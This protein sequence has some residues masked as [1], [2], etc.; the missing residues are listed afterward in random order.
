MA[1]DTLTEL[2][3]RIDFA[4]ITSMHIIYPPLTIGLAALLFFSEWRWLRTGEDSW[5][6][7]TRFYEKL[8]IINFGAGVAT[9]VTMEMAFGILYGPFSTAVGPV[10]GHLLGTETITAFMYEAG[11][12]GLMVFGWHKINPYVHL[13]A[14]FNVAFAS[15]LSAFWIL[16]ANSWMQTP[17]GVAMSD[18][19]FY[20]TDWLKVIFNEDSL[21]AT[22]HMLLACL[23]MGLYFVAGVAAWQ[24]LNKRHTLLFQR[25]LKYAVLAMVIVAGYQIWHGDELGLT[26][27]H[28][29]PAALAAM[30]GHF[31]TYLPNGDPNT[32]WNL[33]MWPNQD[34]SA[35]LW[36]ISIP[37]VLSLLETHTWSGMVPGLDQFPVDER[38][39]VVIP[40]YGFRIMVAIGFLLFLVAL[41]GGYLWLRGRFSPDKIVE[42]RWFL[43]SLVVSAFFPY[44]A[45]WTG[46]WT[47]EV[48]RQPWIVYGLMRT[49]EGRSDLSFGEALTWFIGFASFELIVMV[50]TFYYF[51]KV[52]KKG[53]DTG[54]VPDSDQTKDKLQ[55]AASKAHGEHQL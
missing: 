35:A 2:L 6:Q 39:P 40:F 54:S 7:L 50:S 19:Y 31:Q 22:P 8:F 33:L 10:F 21:T 48:A 3:T 41:W 30:E 23:E 42:Q 47:R 14:T 11:F 43:R 51:S 46:W 52:I 34:K 16:A 37:H 12:L 28:H 24:L 36:S 29:Q 32:S 18:G 13:F 26:V 5:Y 25:V 4:L 53:P 27:A 38:P 20:A 44:V 49:S 55:L 17:N 15:A 9:G 1:P 45:I